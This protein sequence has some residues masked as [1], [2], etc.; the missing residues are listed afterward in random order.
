MKKIYITEE[1]L[2][3]AKKTIENDKYPILKELDNCHLL[4]NPSLPSNGIV[5]FNKTLLKKRFD[6]IKKQ[7]SK[8][9]KTDELKDINVYKNELSKLFKKISD[10]ETTATTTTTPTTTRQTITAADEPPHY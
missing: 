5:D 8:I 3:I 2:N 7:L 1:K 4:N 10:I 6:E 9:T